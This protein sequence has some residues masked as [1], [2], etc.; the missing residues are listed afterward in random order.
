MRDGSKLRI[1]IDVKHAERGHYEAVMANGISCKFDPKDRAGG[2]PNDEMPITHDTIPLDT[3]V[4][5]RRLHAVAAGRAPSENALALGELHGKDESVAHLEATFD[6]KTNNL[7]PQKVANPGAGKEHPFRAWR[8]E[9]DNDDKV[10]MRKIE[11]EELDLEADDEDSE[12]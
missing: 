6:L 4:G 8:L 11:P 12:G 9:D 2:N 5:S 10:S 1:L 3:P 7:I